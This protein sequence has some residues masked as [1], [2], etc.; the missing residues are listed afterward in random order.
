VL[1][2][3]ERTQLNAATLLYYQNERLMELCDTWKPDYDIE[4]HPEL[5]T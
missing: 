4:T 1:T 3:E 5:L 2:D